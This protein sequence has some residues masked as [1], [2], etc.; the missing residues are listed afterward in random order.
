[1]RI[2]L[3]LIFALLTL[4][5][6]V[7]YPQDGWK[8]GTA[9]TNI[10]PEENMWMAGF[11]SRTKPSDGILHDLWAKA[12]VLEDAQG[13]RALLI[14][15]DILG[16]PRELSER[17]RQQ[18]FDKHKLTKEQ[19]ILSSSHS[20]SS[21]VLE[22][23]LTSVYPL[24][25]READKIKR[26]TVLL[27]RKIIDLATTALQSLQ[28][29]KLYSQNGVVRFQVNRRNNEE[30]NIR[31]LSELKGP[32]DYSVPVIKVQNAQ[33]EIVAIIFGYAC[34]PTVLTGYQWS[35]DYPGFAQIGL[36][37]AFPKANAMFFQG[38]G[39]DQNALPRTTV[40]LARQ[41]GR[42]LASAVERVLE[43]KMDELSPRLT[44]VYSEIDLLL[45]SPPDESELQNIVQTTSGYSKRWAA[46]MLEK[47]K[48]K[49]VL[50]TSYPYPVQAWMI[51]EQ[52]LVTLGG[53]VTIE[54]A[55]KI[56]Q[57]FG[58]HTFVMTYA[59]DLMGYIP[60]LKIL[61]EGGYE[62]ERAQM[63]YGLPAK[64]DASIETTI[65]NEVIRIGK[66]AG[67]PLP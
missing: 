32:N 7:S 13:K 3:F 9:R 17:I 15:T 67:F 62:G 43:D 22:N 2:T 60:S 37:K 65:L 52:P 5:P 39:A 10:T 38:A 47:I 12:L 45:S 49:E 4:L 35:G 24:Y 61:K 66:K 8:A 40:P 48:K 58:N 19:V 26:Y 28:P 30:K 42:E 31:S 20:H 25:D 29:V 16:F 11:A 6:S 34:H 41:Y 53:E 64:W 63:V 27:E 55:I 56:K 18:L 59:N 33:S 51:G 54:Y 50:I 46:T 44:T 14:T 57:I 23:S 1:M 21:P 36:E